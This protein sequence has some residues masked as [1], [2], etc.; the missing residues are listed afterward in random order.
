MLTKWSV[1]D[2]RIGWEENAETKRQNSKAEYRTDD[3][4]QKNE[5]GI[6]QSD[7]RTSFDVSKL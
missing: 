4:V 7:T 5:S 2:I 1:A 6:W 3:S